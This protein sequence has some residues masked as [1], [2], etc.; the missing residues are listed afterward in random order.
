MIP[1]RRKARGGRQN[2]GD[3]RTGCLDATI[4]KRPADKRACLL[5]TQALACDD[6]VQL[7]SLPLADEA[8]PFLADIGELYPGASGL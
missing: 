8:F 2:T 5:G 4:A 7:G 3:R 6:L 1:G